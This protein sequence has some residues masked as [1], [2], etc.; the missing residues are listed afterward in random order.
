M[1]LILKII[2]EC[3]EYTKIQ[4]AINDYKISNSYSFIKNSDFI[5]FLVKIKPDIML[6][7]NG[8]KTTL[9]ILIY[10]YKKYDINNENTTKNNRN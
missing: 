6:T 4:I 9:P 5:D 3:K 2:K 10:R 7:E 1:K 8:I